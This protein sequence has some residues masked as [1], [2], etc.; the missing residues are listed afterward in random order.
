MSVYVVDEIMGRGKSSAAINFINRSGT[1]TRWMVIVPYKTEI[2]RFMTACSARH[3]CTPDEK[4][5]KLRNIKPLL[6][7]R[8]NIVATHALFGMFDSEVLRLIEAGGYTLVMDEVTSVLE[9]ITI[10][11]HDTQLLANG[12]V[13]ID[14]DKRVVW[15]D[16]TYTGKFDAYKE[17]EETRNVYE[18]YKNLWLS[19]VPPEVFTV[20]RDVYLMTYMFEHQMQR[21][22]FDFIGLKYEYIHVS[23]DC[24]ENYMFSGTKCE[25]RKVDYKQM[26]HILHDQKMNAIGEADYALSKTWYIRNYNAPG[27]A[28]LKNHTYNFFRNKLRSPA[29][30]NIWT[31]FGEDKDYGIDFH[32]KLSGKGY[33]SGFIACNAKG[34]NEFRSKTSLAYLINRYPITSEQNF[35]KSHGIQLDSDF[36]ALSEMLQW[37]WRSAIRDGKEIAIYVPS[38]RM[39]TL[40]EGWIERVR[41]CA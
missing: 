35:L 21:C 40:L 20:F 30:C 8:R 2:S 19:L 5:G 12:L 36:F 6:E 29:S 17:K 39:R 13:K 38:K 11:P 24:Q 22:Y 23:G 9:S 32:K 25:S 16:K 26:I 28:E 27:M 4:G 7:S 31:A 18:Y 3:F 37:I 1:D 14:D 33:A 34:T 41:R 15:L 10:T